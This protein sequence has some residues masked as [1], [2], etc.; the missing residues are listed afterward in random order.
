MAS[1]PP[2]FVLLGP[3]LR[4]QQPGSGGCM[5]VQAIP[6]LVAQIL[7]RKWQSLHLPGWLL[8]QCNMLVNKLFSRSDVNASS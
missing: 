3:P 1:A 5:K 4:K 2:A 7:L 6:G 8:E